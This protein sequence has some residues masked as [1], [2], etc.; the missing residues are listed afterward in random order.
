MGPVGLA[1]LLEKG[2]DALT[3]WAWSRSWGSHVE[4]PEGNWAP[5]DSSALS[6][7]LLAQLPSAR[8]S[9]CLPPAAL[10]PGSSSSG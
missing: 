6:Q 7:G 2:G 3:F 8:P 5:I 1:V 9:L 4:N 10:W